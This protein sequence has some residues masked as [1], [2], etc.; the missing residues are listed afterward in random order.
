MMKLSLT[1]LAIPKQNWRVARQQISKQY[2]KAKAAYPG[3]SLKRIPELLDRPT[4]KTL[5]MNLAGDGRWLWIIGT[6][7]AGGIFH[8][9]IVLSIPSLASRTAW[10]RLEKIAPVNQMHVL[11]RA[12]EESHPLPFMA[13]DIRYAFCRF[14]LTAGSVKVT[15]PVRSAVWSI[16]IYS[17]YGENFYS[18]S[19]ADLQR[20]RIQMIIVDGAQAAEA[21]ADIADTSEELVIVKSP[22]TRGILLIRAPLSGQSLHSIIDDA[23]LQADCRAE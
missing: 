23:L 13:P 16:A 8:I 1:D 2:E 7:L 4:T 19:S 10:D 6:V 20:V 15:A 3:L 9:L 5:Y 21:E 17:P 11:R 22:H 12:S 18:I 14:D